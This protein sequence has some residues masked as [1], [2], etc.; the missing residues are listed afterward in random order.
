MIALLVP[1]NL[2]DDPT[3]AC[4]HLNEQ[5]Y[6][7]CVVLFQKGFQTDIRTAALSQ[8]VGCRPMPANIRV[9]QTGLFFSDAQRADI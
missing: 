7:V 6:G 4:T 2:D 9:I 3:T 5:A 1:D 8:S